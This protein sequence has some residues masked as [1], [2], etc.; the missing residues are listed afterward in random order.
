[1]KPSKKIEFI[2]RVNKSY[3]GLEGLQIVVNCDKTN[4][5]TI[6]EEQYQFETIGNRCL[7]EGTAKEVAKKYGLQEGIK[8][9][10]KLHEERIK[11]YIENEE[12]GEKYNEKRN[13]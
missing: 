12:K 6:E 7:K 1:M 4:N 2:E 5:N 8:L 3:L 9:G 10:N 11:W 13:R